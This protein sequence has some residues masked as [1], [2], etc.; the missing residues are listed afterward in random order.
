MIVWTVL[1]WASRYQSLAVDDW[2]NAEPHML[3]RDDVRP[4][5]SS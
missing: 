4:V 1:N 5:P 2:T 3:R